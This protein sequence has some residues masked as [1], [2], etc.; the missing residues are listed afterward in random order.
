MYFLFSL[1]KKEKREIVH[2]TLRHMQPVGSILPVWF[3]VGQRGM[4]EE[5]RPIAMDE[6]SEKSLVGAYVSYFCSLLFWMCMSPHFF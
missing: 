1:W 6:G 2:L 4:V 3:M 5:K